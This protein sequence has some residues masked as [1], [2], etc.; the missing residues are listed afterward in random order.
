MSASRRSF[1]LSLL[2]DHLAIVRLTP[3]ADV[4]PWASRGAFFS[5]TRTSDELSIVCA[6][7]SLPA[8]VPADMSSTGWRLFKVHGPFALSE[9]GVLSA[10]AAPLA[11]AG[12]SIFVISTF[13]TDY[14]LV[15]A[16]Q[17]HGAVAALEHAGHK[18]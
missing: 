17:L 10:M 8:H 11:E 5:A 4:P 15:K 3:D 2:P 16:E 1:E 12:V 6:G 13:D 9:V 18:V 7:S 14:F